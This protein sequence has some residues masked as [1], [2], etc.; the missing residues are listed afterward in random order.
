MGLMARVHVVWTGLPGYP[1]LTTFWFGVGTSTASTRDAAVRTFLNGIKADVVIGISMTVQPEQTIIESDTGLPT[2]VEVGP[3]ALAIG[4]SNS[5]ELAP[6]A[7]QGLL[8]LSTAHYD[9]AR[10]LQ[11]RIYLG[12]MSQN[13]SHGV[14]IPAFITRMNTAAETLRSSMASSG[15]WM[16]YSRK[17]STAAPV[18]AVTCWDNW[19]VLRSRRD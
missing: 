15:P 4:G 3:G 14:P 1:G 9:G 12:G 18:T 19:A 17:F 5:G 7:T 10:R 13:N 6:Y 8:R 2:G 11:G 16:V